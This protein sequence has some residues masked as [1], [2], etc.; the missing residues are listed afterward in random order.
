MSTG[1][2]LS[3]PTVRNMRVARDT[4]TGIILQISGTNPVYGDLLVEV[5]SIAALPLDGAP[6]QAASTLTDGLA[7]SDGRGVGPTPG[8]A[9]SLRRP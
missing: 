7:T 2:D 3:H 1:F 4:Q 9:D 5:T 6:F 8:S